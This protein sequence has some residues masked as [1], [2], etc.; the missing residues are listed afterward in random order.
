MINKQYDII[1][2][3]ENKTIILLEIKL[4]NTIVDDKSKLYQWFIYN[5]VNDELEPLIY[6]SRKNEN[7][8]EYRVFDNSTLS[9]DD[10]KA[11]YNTNSKDI[12]LN[13]IDIE[14]P[15]DKRINESIDDYFIFLKMKNN[16]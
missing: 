5:K 11:I 12:E 15:V 13:R 9:F 14:L 4:K 16:D 6:Q 3:F 1:Y 8:T 7:N 10:K 2:L